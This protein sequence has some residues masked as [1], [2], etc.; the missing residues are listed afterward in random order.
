MDNLT[1]VIISLTALVTAVGGLIVAFK[2]TKKELVESI[3]KRIKKQ[4]DIDTEIVKRMEQVKEIVGA[5]RVQI[6]DFH[7]GIHYA[8]GRSALKVSCSYE[9]CRIGC[10]PSQMLLQG[11]PIS[12]IPQFIRNIINAGEMKT[13]NLEEIKNT[14]PSTYELKKSQNVKSFYDIILSNKEGEPIGFLAIQFTKINMVD[15]TDVKKNEI[16][17]LKFFI[18]ENLEKMVEKKNGGK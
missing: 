6:Y 14:M 13:S 17:R 1:T 9:V 5:D 4:T 11:I 10:K 15:F 8:N 2:K 7:N 3:P 18:E 16:L 12:C